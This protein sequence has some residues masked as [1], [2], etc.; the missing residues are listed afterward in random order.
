MLPNRPRTFDSAPTSSSISSSANS[1]STTTSSSSCSSS[2]A[3]QHAYVTY[4]SVEEAQRAAQEL[5][6]LPFDAELRVSFA[7][8]KDELDK[9]R[10]D[11]FL[12][13]DECKEKS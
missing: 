1:S 8:S 12:E 11:D 13:L 7:I 10:R 3:K 4:S 6:K 9:V 5:T 2:K